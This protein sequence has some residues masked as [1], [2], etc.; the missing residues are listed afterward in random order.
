[1]KSS[2]PT[3]PSLLF[4]SFSF[5][6]FSLSDGVDTAIT[7]VSTKQ[8]GL[9]FIPGDLCRCQAPGEDFYPSRRHLTEEEIGKHTERSTVRSLQT[10]LD[11]V[12]GLYIV[13]GVFVLPDS[14]PNC[15]S[16]TAAF[17]TPSYTGTSTYRTPKYHGSSDDP[18]VFGKLGDRN[19]MDAADSDTMLDA[20]GH[21]EMEN[22]VSAHGKDHEEAA[23]LELEK[24]EQRNL[25]AIYHKE[26]GEPQASQVE[27][28]QTPQVTARGTYHKKEE[29][30]PETS[31]VGGP[32]TSQI[33]G[34]QTSQVTNRGPRPYGTH[35]YAA[36][37]EYGK[38]K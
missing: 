35:A 21:V 38:G 8:R 10:L 5:Q 14:D 9:Q 31:Q 28:P 11:P 34:P 24:D 3:V 30:E 16:S 7:S 19:L 33:E 36:R 1:M 26:E 15:A 2:S 18:D 23:D 6:A 13:D 25:Q 37:P 22:Y 4:A 29:G 12:T 27:V 32:Q 20:Y 17:S